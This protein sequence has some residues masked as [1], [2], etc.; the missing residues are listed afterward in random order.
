MSKVGKLRETT[1][2]EKQQHFPFQSDSPERLRLQHPLQVVLPLLVVVQPQVEELPD[3]VQLGGVLTKATLGVEQDHRG[4][5]DRRL[6]KLNWHL[7][8][9]GK[10]VEVGF[11]IKP[12]A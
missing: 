1:C 5:G 12:A 8:I 3:D 10:C 11:F 6:E 2:F 7:K 9:C 4:G